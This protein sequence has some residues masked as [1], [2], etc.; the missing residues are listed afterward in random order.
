[1]SLRERLWWTLA[2]RPLIGLLVPDRP[3]ET[4]PDHVPCV[5]TRHAYLLYDTRAMSYLSRRF[6]PTNPQL[7]WTRR[8]DEAYRFASERVARQV[9]DEFGGSFQIKTQQL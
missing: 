7:R 5:K 4:P 9:A 6:D 1:V 8:L 2:T 3:I